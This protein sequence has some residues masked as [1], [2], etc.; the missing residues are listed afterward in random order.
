MPYMGLSGRD[1]RIF[2]AGTETICIEDGHGVIVQLH[3]GEI[4]RI[5]TAILMAA[6]DAVDYLPYI[7][8]KYPNEESDE[9]Q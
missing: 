7:T 5:A 3:R 1:W 4:I 9:Q 8:E 6:G 2:W